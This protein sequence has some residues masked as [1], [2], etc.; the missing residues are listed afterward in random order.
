[1]STILEGFYSGFQWV[2]GLG[3]GGILAIAL[4]LL[5]LLFKVGVGK[6]IR[7]ALTSAVG[8]IGL[9]LVVDMLIAV[10]GPATAAMV[11]R[12]GWQLDIVDVGWGLIGMAWGNPSAPFVIIT[13]IVLNIALILVGFTKTLMIDFWNYWSFAAAGA[14]AYGATQNILYSVLVAAIYMAVCWKVGDWVAE[15]S[16]QEFYGLPGITWPTGAVIPPIIIGYPV[17]KLLQKIPF[18]KDVQADPDTLQDKFGVLGEPVII[19]AILGWLIGILAGFSAQDVILMGI[20][21]AAVLV[22]VPRMIQVLM[23]GLLAISDGAQEF[24]K[25]YF[26]GREIYIGIDAST[27]LGHPATL[28][29]ILIM[30]PIV[31]IMSIIPGNRLLA[32]ASLAAIPWFLIPLTSFAKGNVLH[33]CLAGVVVF[34]VYFWCAT[35]LAPAHTQLALLTGFEI[36]EGAQL[37]GSLSEGGNFIT[38]I[39]VELSKLFGLYSV[40]I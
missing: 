2:T 19:G 35:L 28:S 4:F 24:T 12:L 15:K 16:Y 6:A 7:S 11:E 5:G 26:K 1:V 3:G 14:L 40:G 25:K 22:L 21:L 27:I 29:S 30:T 17:I 34:A 23:E 18:I 36:P 38:W 37:I 10:M 33:I 31:V 9:F 20:R 32:V 13:A 39:L 8:F